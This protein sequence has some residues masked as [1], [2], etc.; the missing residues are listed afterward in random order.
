MADLN[1]LMV[2]ARSLDLFKPHGAFEVHC[3]NCHTRLDPSG[4]CPTCGLIGR[5]EAEVE[6]RARNDPAGAEKLLQ[7]AIAK[8]KAYQP[9]KP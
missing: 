6:K 7:G 2:E 3:G 5:P 1:A 9:A 8:R 4:D